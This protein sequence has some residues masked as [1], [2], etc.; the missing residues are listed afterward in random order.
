M[1]LAGAAGFPDLTGRTSVERAL[2]VQQP[3]V[4][5]PAAGVL[6]HPLGC[7]DD[8]QIPGPAHPRVAM[9]RQRSGIVIARWKG[10]WEEGFMTSGVRKSS[11]YARNW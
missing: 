6:Q 7:H 9:D 1:S 4:E 5:F 8:E 11:R 3:Q 2:V 10:R